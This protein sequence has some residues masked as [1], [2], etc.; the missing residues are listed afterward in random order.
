MQLGKERD[1]TLALSRDRTMVVITRFFTKEEMEARGSDL[2]AQLFELPK[3]A[4]VTLLSMY[5]T[6]VHPQLLKVMYGSSEEKKFSITND[7]DYI[8]LDGK[9][10]LVHLRKYYRQK[11][12]GVL[13]PGRS[14]VALIPSEA[15]DLFHHL[16]AYLNHLRLP[17]RADSEEEQE[18]LTG[19]LLG[20]QE[21]EEDTDSG[22]Y[23]MDQSQPTDFLDDEEEGDDE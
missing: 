3:T 4:V 11:P 17:T 12:T 16:S 6:I 5:K 7:M 19:D 14:G 21:E 23:V 13:K 8:V 20:S 18:D 22:A 10:Q 1:T 2:N 15:V 9:M